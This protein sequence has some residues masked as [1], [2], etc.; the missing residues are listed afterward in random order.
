MQ[1]YKTHTINSDHQNAVIAIGNFDGVHK[2]HQ[3]LIGR[4]KALADKHGYPLGVLTF[5]PHPRYFFNPDQEPFSLVS[6][7]HKNTLLHE[8]CDV[9]FVVEITFDKKFSTLT[10][11]QFIQNILCDGLQ[12]A[13]IVIGHDFCFGAG[14]SGNA[15]T[16]KECSSFDTTIVEPLSDTDQ[17]IFSSSNIRHALRRGD[18]TSANQLLGW[19]WVIKSTVI[20]GDKRGRELGY[21]TA[22]MALGDI[23]C[24]ATGVY[25]SQTKLPNGTLVNSITN[26]GIRPMFKAKKP[27]VETFIFDYKGDLYD[28]VLEIKPLAF[29]RDEAKF[30]SLDA[31]VVQ[32]GKDCK[33]AKAIQKNI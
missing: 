33:Q 7:D 2:G 3:E 29:L 30:N 11:D 26:I 6:T 22:N 9:D 25:A 24:P 13:H 1:V 21:P 10:A 27:L 23:I 4:A 12:A 18:L 15:D 17:T 14:R 32:M 31:L 8:L 5:S 20:H 28:Q 16:L 19:D